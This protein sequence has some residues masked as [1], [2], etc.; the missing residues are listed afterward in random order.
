MKTPVFFIGERLSGK[1]RQ[2]LH[3]Q[4]VQFIEQPFFRTE[5]KRPNLKFFGTMANRNKQWIVTSSNAAQWLVRFHAKIGVTANDRVFCWSEKQAEILSRINVTV[6]VTSYADYESLAQRVITQNQGEPIVYLSDGQPISDVSAVF[7]TSLI[8]FTEVVVY[9][10]KPIHQFVRGIFD[11]YLFFSPSA[12]DHFKAAGNFTNP[13][14][15]VVA[16]ENS[17]ARAAW[18]SFTNKVYLSPEK[19]EFSF[20]QYAISNWKEED[21]KPEQTPKWE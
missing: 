15:V 16:N 2:W 5:Y 14:S 6:F 7:S 3:K 12:I 17:T 18:R 10:N 9:K 1:T 19:E 11:A 4:Q 21:C 20:V 13:V 8:P